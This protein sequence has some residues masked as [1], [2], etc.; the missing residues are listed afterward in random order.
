MTR[1]IVKISPNGTARIYDTWQ[2]E[3]LLRR[4]AELSRALR[5]ASQLNNTEY[6][7]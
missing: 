1:Y 4:F 3:T 2:C 7:T 5:V 6:T